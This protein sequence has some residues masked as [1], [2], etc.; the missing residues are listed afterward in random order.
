M[1]FDFQNLYFNHFHTLLCFVLFLFLYFSYHEAAGLWHLFFLLDMILGSGTQISLGQGFGW[2]LK[3][4]HVS[5]GSFLQKKYPISKDFSFKIDLFLENF[6]FLSM[7][8][9]AYRKL[10]PMWKDYCARINDPLEWHI[11]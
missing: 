11:L 3:P 7:F 10:V 4:T 1:Y 5:K 6:G 9:A 2:R 8:D